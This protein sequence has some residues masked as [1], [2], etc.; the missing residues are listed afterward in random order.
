[1][2]GRSWR[3]WSESEWCCWSGRNGKRKGRLYQSKQ[4]V[5]TA[6]LLRS[7]NSMEFSELQSS[8]YRQKSITYILRLSPVFARME[9]PVLSPVSHRIWILVTPHVIY[10]G[11]RA[12][13][14]VLAEEKKAQAEEGTQTEGVRVVEKERGGKEKGRKGA[15]V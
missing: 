7:S 1:M 12:F 5:W 2:R 10:M 14:T 13:P 4:L 11:A 9:Y 15:R 3:V 6:K 8:R